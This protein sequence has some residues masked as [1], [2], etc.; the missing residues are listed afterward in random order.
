MKKIIIALVFLPTLVFAAPP[1]TVPVVTPP[2]FNPLSPVPAPTPF[3]WGMLPPNSLP[4]GVSVQGFPAPY[5]KPVTLPLSPV[6]EENNSA[7]KLTK[8]VIRGTTAVNV[9]FSLSRNELDARMRRE[10][11]ARQLSFM[12]D[13]YNLLGPDG[14]VGISNRSGGLVIRKN[15][16]TP[17]GQQPDDIRRLVESSIPR[18]TTPAE[19]R[20]R[21]DEIERITKEVSDALAAY[22]RAQ[23]DLRVNLDTQRQAGVF[24]PLLSPPQLIAMA[25]QHAKATESFKETYAALAQD[26]EKMRVAT[27]KNGAK[28]YDRDDIEKAQQQANALNRDAA[29]RQARSAAQIAFEGRR[30][31]MDPAQV[32]K[33][34][35]SAIDWMQAAEQLGK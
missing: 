26:I 2:I 8:E 32:E 22:A 10:A 33:Y 21:T 29:L 18:G 14:G 9:A 28:R 25:G 31:G 23:N 34:M 11:A 12:L 13:D 16:K 24:L 19:V 3:T 15:P 17:I 35:Q 6:R 4:P 5:A 1:A 27:D 30:I 7:F 20:E